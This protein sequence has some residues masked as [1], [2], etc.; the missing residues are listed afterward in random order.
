MSKPMTV[1]T[2]E[3]LLARTVEVGDCLEW[4]GYYQNGT[5]YVCVGHKTMVSVRKVLAG[6]LDL[7][8]RNSVYW[9]VTCANPRCVNPEHIIG[10]NRGQHMAHMAKN[11]D[12]AGARRVAKL[13]ASA[14]ARGVTKVGG[15][16]EAEA[17]RLDPRSCAAVAQEYGISKSL[18]SKIKRGDAWRPVSAAANP[19]AGLM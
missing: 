7:G 16:A 8:G 17:I 18:V 3:S 4:T 19:W 15:E 9:S 5:P 6:M 13:Q 11:V 10:R 2:V 12:H 1:H 14:R